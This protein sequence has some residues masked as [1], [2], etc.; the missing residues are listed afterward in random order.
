MSCSRMRTSGLSVLSFAGV[1]S[2]AF[3]PSAVLFAAVVG[4]HPELII[5][6]VGAAFLW[7]CAISLV[8]AIWAV[9]VPV[10]GVLWLVVLYAVL[11][12]EGCRWGTYTL[13]HR[14]LQGLRAMGLQ[15]APARGAASATVEA[16]QLVP[17]AVASG[18][19]A[20]L[21]QALVMYGDVLGGALR[22]GTR[23]SP[24]CAQL[25]AFALDALQSLGF[26]VLHV[27]L[28]MIGWTAAYPRHSR[29]LRVVIVLLHYG[30][31]AATLLNT[32]A[33]LPDGEGCTIA[34]SSLLA[35][36]I[37]AGGITAHV[38][39]SHLCVA[40][41]KSSIASGSTRR[42]GQADADRL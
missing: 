2:A 19:G 42:Q 4:K 34:L 21:M 25:S 30:A 1:V 10:R 11:L 7:L 41:N 29:P 35:M 27:L 18:L 33:L 16:G 15:P 22:P 20:G 39:T 24:A 40:P 31:S 17:A 14:L 28:C 37:V 9:F 32:S 23:Y 3:A 38:V 13:Y 26:Q 36:V 8:A 12:Q 6:L 5:L